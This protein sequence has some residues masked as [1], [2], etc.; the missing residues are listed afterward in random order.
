MRAAL[1]FALVS[2]AGA[3]LLGAC[4]GNDVILATT[5]STQ[6]SGLLDALIPEFEKQTGYNV[7]TIAVGS[8][9]ALKMAEEGNADVLMVH[10]PSA[11]KELMD[12]GHGVDRRLVMY[13]YFLVVGP[14]SDPAGIQGMGSASE[15]LKAI[16]DAGRLFVSRGDDSGTHRKEMAFWRDVGVDPTGESW[17]QETGQGMGGTL[18]IASEKEGYTLTD[19]ATYARLGKRLRLEPMVDGDPVLINIYHV[20]RVN[21]EKHGGLN[22]EG[23]KAWADFLVSPEAQRLIGDFGVEEFGRPLFIPAAGQDEGALGQW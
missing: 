10:A 5:T 16:A 13:N 17:Y 7:K 15:A 23:A 4:G 11:E 8:G 19:Q 12:A 6:D 18:L 2:L 1:P 22:V 21:P 9:A 3:L 20:I 14:A